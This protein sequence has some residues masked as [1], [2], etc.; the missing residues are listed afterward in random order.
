MY[1]S[2][3]RVGSWWAV[4]VCG[5]LVQRLKALSLLPP[6]GAKLGCSISVGE[7]GHVLCACGNRQGSGRC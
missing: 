5:D 7:G 4:L 3:N 2:G 1:A 6:A